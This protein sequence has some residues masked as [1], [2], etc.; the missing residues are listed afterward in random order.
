MTSTPFLW[1][2]SLPNLG[3]WHS[4]VLRGGDDDPPLTKKKTN[5]SFFRVFLL[6][7]IVAR[8]RLVLDFSL[9]LLLYHVVMTSLYSDHVPT[10]FLWWALNGTTA[11]IMI[12]GGEYVCMQQEMEPILLGGGASRNNTT[13]GPS[14]DTMHASRS[15]TTTGSGTNHGGGGS[16]GGGGNSTGQNMALQGASLAG[17]HHDGYGY[18]ESAGLLM[19]TFDGNTLDQPPARS[20]TQKARSS[21][22]TGIVRSGSRPTIR[23]SIQHVVGRQR[24]SDGYKPVPHRSMTADNETS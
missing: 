13:N 24:T 15:N 6:L 10:S 9:T 16:S 14:G 5:Y 22:D 11:G 17:M 20:M 8:A 4:I 1:T 23:S 19:D 12:F 2:L 21:E 7:K 18:D 3:T